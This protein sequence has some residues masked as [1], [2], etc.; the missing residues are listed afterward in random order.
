MLD[1]RIARHLTLAD[2]QWR[3]VGFIIPPDR[4]RPYRRV[5]LTVTA[6]AG[7]SAVIRLGRPDAKHQ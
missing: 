2:D 3:V 6:P 5:D 1:G 7:A 4:N